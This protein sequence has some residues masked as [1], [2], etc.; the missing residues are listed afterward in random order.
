MPEFIKIVV[1]SDA[2]HTLVKDVYIKDTSSEYWSEVHDPRHF[3]DYPFDYD[4]MW[5]MCV[6]MFKMIQDEDGV[7]LDQ[8]TLD[9]NT[10]ADEK[11]YKLYTS[12]R[13]HFCN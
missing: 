11:L 1:W 9:I 5:P 10:H 13:R 2:S 8:S 4:Q 6:R 7:P 12:L 3:P